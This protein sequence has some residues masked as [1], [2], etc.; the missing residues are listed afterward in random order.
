RRCAA[1]ASRFSDPTCSDPVWEASTPPPGRAA[2]EPMSDSTYRK[3][4]LPV[5]LNLQDRNTR[6]QIQSGTDEKASNRGNLEGV[7]AVSGTRVSSAAQS[8]K[9]C[10]DVMR[11]DLCDWLDSHGVAGAPPSAEAEQRAMW[12]WIRDFHKEY[13]DDW[14]SRNMPRLHEQFRP[15]F[16]QEMKKRKAE[17]APPAAA[18]APDLLDLGGGAAPA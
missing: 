16:V 18:P 5:K 3:T 8:Q 7:K 11:K 4:A 6:A 12:S 2:P 9:G 14:F 10:T 13:S 17:A 1:D 15:V